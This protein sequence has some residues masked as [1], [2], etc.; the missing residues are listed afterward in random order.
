MIHDFSSDLL[1]VPIGTILL[2]Y[3]PLVLIDVVNQILHPF[4]LLIVINLLY[5]L[6]PHELWDNH[7][8]EQDYL[9]LL[10]NEHI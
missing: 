9:K 1:I 5:P 6:R 2:Y 4:S 7:V 8:V 3:R 10:R